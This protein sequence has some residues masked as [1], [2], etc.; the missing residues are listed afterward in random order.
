MNAR[1]IGK[2][3]VAVLA[4][5]ALTAPGCKLERQSDLMGPQ[6]LGRE[7]DNT[8]ADQMTLQQELQREQVHVARLNAEVGKL[9]AREEALSR[10]ALDL[11]ARIDDALARI[12]VQQQRLVEAEAAAAAAKALLEGGGAEP[13]G[14]SAAPAGEPASAPATAPAGSGGE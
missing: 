8:V 4:L 12:A 2:T 5:V 1:V 11:E 3:P 6:Y 14:E 10:E 9:R 13:P 7:I